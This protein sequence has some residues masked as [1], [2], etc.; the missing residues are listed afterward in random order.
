[1]V[2]FPAVKEPGAGLRLYQ[3]NAEHQGQL[4]QEFPHS[5]RG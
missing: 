2:P 3:Q 1:M 5:A 4:L